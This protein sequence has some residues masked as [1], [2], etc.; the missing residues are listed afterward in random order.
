MVGR[1]VSSLS[2]NGSCGTC[3]W[4]LEQVASC[5]WTCM[6]QSIGMGVD[7]I[8]GDPEGGEGPCLPLQRFSRKAAT[9]PGSSSEYTGGSSPAL[10]LLARRRPGWSCLSGGRGKDMGSLF[11][12]CSLT[13][14]P[15]SQLPL[16]FRSFHFTVSRLRLTLG[17][18]S[19]LFHTSL[20]STPNSGSRAWLQSHTE[21]PHP[22]NAVQLP[23]RH[24]SSFIIIIIFWRVNTY[25]FVICFTGPPCKTNQWSLAEK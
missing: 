22:T 6:S 19:L 11:W 24:I 4:D 23:C 2:D 25:W 7:S 16:I 1:L 3:L 5:S 18:A 12:V 21:F 8:Q 10:G 17:W 15:P 20:P 14:L 13:T 9:W